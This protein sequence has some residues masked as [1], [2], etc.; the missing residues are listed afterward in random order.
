[1][2]PFP[3]S[4][5]NPKIANTIPKNPSSVIFSLKKNNPIIAIKIGAVPII[6]PVLAA[7]VNCNPV[8]CIHK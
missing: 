5:N 4:I 7:V 2:S 3:N 8:T 6:H 1:M